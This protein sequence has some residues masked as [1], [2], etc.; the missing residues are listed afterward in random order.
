MVKTAYDGMAG[1]GVFT[2]YLLQIDGLEDF[3]LNTIK[4][5]IA[6]CIYFKSFTT[7]PK[8]RG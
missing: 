4:L 2:E 3:R 6:T 5:K 7:N 1:K 8:S